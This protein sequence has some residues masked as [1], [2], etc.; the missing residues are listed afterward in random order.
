M[1]FN[2]EHMDA[3]N[4]GCDSTSVGG[5]SGYQ[6]VGG[7]VSK[8]LLAA[9]AI[10]SA[11]Q[12][13]HIVP[14]DVVWVEDES[15]DSILC[16]QLGTVKQTH[17]GIDAEFVPA[18]SEYA[19]ELNS[20]HLRKLVSF[21]QASR[22]NCLTV[23]H[24]TV[25]NG[26]TQM[27]GLIATTI[28]CHND[29]QL[30]QMGIP[31]GFTIV[32]DSD[33][34]D[35]TRKFLSL[36]GFFKKFDNDDG[37]EDTVLPEGVDCVS[38]FKKYSGFLGGILIV[39][40][41]NDVFWLPVSKN[42]SDQNQ[43]TAGVAR[44]FA[45]SVSMAYLHNLAGIG[46]ASIWGET[47][48]FDDQNH[49]AQVLREQMVLTGCGMNLTAEHDDWKTVG[50]STLVGLMG[51]CGLAHMCDVPV[52]IKG[53]EAITAFFNDLDS[54]RNIMTDKIFEE[55]LSKHFP[56]GASMKHREI[57]GNVLEGL[58]LVLYNANGDYVG[59]LKY[60]FP[61]YT[62][63]TFMLR[64]AGDKLKHFGTFVNQ[65]WMPSLT[66][67]NLMESYLQRWVTREDDRG[68]WRKFILAAAERMDT[69]RDRPNDE[70]DPIGVHIRAADGV[71]ET[72]C[73]SLSFSDLI[74]QFCVP[75]LNGDDL[76]EL[77]N[78]KLD[79]GIYTVEMP[80]G[81][82]YSKWKRGTRGKRGKMYRRKLRIHHKTLF[83]VK[84]IGDASQPP[85]VIIRGAPGSGKSTLARFLAKE[86][87]EAYA[88]DDIVDGPNGLPQATYCAHFTNLIGG[89]HGACQA[90]CRAALDSGKTVFIHNTS[91][92]LWELRPYL[93]MTGHLVIID[94][95]GGY[96][97]QHGVNAKMVSGM[98]NRIV[99]LEDVT[100]EAVK[101]AKMPR[102][103]GAI[104]VRVSVWVDGVEKHITL[105][106]KPSP[107]TRN[108]WMTLNG[109]PVK[110]SL[111]KVFT[112][113][114]VNGGIVHQAVEVESMELPTGSPV[115]QTNPHFTIKTM[116]GCYKPMDSR[117]LVA[118]TL[119]LRAGHTVSTECPMQCG[120]LGDTG[121]LLVWT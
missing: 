41:A 18:L 78:G 69:L 57:L 109:L 10:L 71:L 4:S 2:Y 24:R 30:I 91:T 43:F 95:I 8:L 118:G 11:S 111:G 74:R 50:T 76:R 54:K 55:L 6:G 65:R 89:A 108:T 82:L 15:F 114:D 121:T 98:R 58:V 52:S 5:T 100:T 56:D 46:V 70:D 107:D 120:N 101:S 94:P 59:T 87:G 1:S 73:S 62:V 64:A 3:R 34:E 45:E 27:G 119:T 104:Q 51:L 93:E 29:R 40:Y 14:K 85:V 67:I 23:K 77:V 61:F 79:D 75:K 66:F 31:R 37:Q 80:G 83:Q 44:L 28:Q 116:D 60:K 21:L 25:V 113:L 36:S 22:K 96:Q 33:E 20:P 84:T 117:A 112:V 47:M 9:L 32:W 88:A 12:G 17:K 35:I 39:P 7:G 48:T 26:S 97:N 110:Y 68:V 81:Y 106:Y 38:F 103:S 99:P 72:L 13:A 115:H 102:K 90:R 16:Q 42:S 105:S 19:E 92:T 63:R 86:F 49:G 53:E